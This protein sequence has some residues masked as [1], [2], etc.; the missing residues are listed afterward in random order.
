M[1][2][3]FCRLC[4]QDGVRTIFNARGWKRHKIWLQSDANGVPVVSCYLDDFKQIIVVHQRSIS[5]EHGFFA[6]DDSDDPHIQMECTCGSK[7][8]SR[9]N[10]FIVVLATNNTEARCL[11]LEREFTDRRVRGSNPTS[12]SR[13]SMSRLGQPGRIPVL[14]LP[15][16]DMAVVYRK[17]VTAE[18]TYTYQVVMVNK[19][20]ELEVCGADPLVERSVARN[21]PHLFNCFCPGLSDPPSANLLTGRSVVRTRLLPLDFPCL[22]LGNLA[23]SQPSCFLRVA[24]QLGTE[25][26]LQLNSQ[27]QKHI[28]YNLQMEQIITKLSPRNWPSNPSKNRPLRKSNLS[29]FR[30]L[31]RPASG[32]ALSLQNYRTVERLQPRSNPTYASP[33]PLPTLGQPGSIPALVIPSSG[34]TEKQPYLKSSPTKHSGVRLE[35]TAPNRFVISASSSF[36][37]HSELGTENSTLFGKRWFGI[38][39]TWPNQ[40]SSWYWS[41]YSSMEVHVAQPKTCFLVTSL[42]ILRHQPTQ[43]TIVSGVFSDCMSM[44]LYFVGSKCIPKEGKTL[45]S[46]AKNTCSLFSYSKT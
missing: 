45:V 10:W 39:N 13:L 42:R 35:P 11:W 43:A 18:R 5:V 32:S 46:S 9:R 20:N 26:V 12:A 1:E 2:V 23:V 36:D 41:W 25:R 14:V 16:D 34:M 22:G 7:S 19:Q 44:T 21:K 17:G 28:R 33:I 38:H 30:L 8:S 40:R 15:S 6:A 27:F 29:K 24:W 3:L 4:F 31:K 37:H